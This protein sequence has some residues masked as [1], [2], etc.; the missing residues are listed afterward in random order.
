MDQVY[1]TTTP[2]AAMGPINSRQAINLF[3]NAPKSIR[4]SAYFGQARMGASPV[5]TKWFD[6]ATF[7]FIDLR[8]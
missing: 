3:T 8:C 1:T 6:G 5:K 4:E 7:V 2:T